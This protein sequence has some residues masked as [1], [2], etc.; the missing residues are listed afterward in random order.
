M[1]DV[2]GVRLTNEQLE[3]LDLMLADRTEPFTNED[4]GWQ[5]LQAVYNALPD[6]L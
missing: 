3:W 1:I 2:S 4:C 6:T 5:I